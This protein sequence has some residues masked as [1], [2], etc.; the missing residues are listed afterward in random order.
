MESANIIEQYLKALEIGSYEEMMK[1]FTPD[2]IVHSP[3][4]GEI[5]ASKFY[6]DLFAD[7]SES[8]IT[9]LNIFKGKDDFIGAGHFRY[10]WKLA[11]GT[12]V[13]FECVDVFKFSNDNL[14]K[15]LTIIYDASATRPAL[16]KMKSS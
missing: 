4:Y 9:L 5:K 7:T 15:E 2:A 16:E 6:K 14:I 10:D 12:P 1:L 11:D 3:L 8:K 13:S